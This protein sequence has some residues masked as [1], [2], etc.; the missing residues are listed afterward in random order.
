MLRLCIIIKD[1]LWQ[2]FTLNLSI[3]GIKELTVVQ[4]TSTETNPATHRY[5]VRTYI[6]GTRH[7]NTSCNERCSTAGNT[8]NAPGAR[9]VPVY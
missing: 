2:R 4:C 7:P 9:G 3:N 5:A 1:G 8:L 6:L